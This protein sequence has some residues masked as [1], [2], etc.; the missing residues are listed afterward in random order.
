LID[1]R[2]GKKLELD[3]SYED[4]PFQIGPQSYSNLPNLRANTPADQVETPNIQIWGS[5]NLGNGTDIF[6][7]VFND[8]DQPVF[9]PTYGNQIQANLLETLL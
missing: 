9:I 8:Q 3:K 7:V 5:A 6:N 4:N 1:K 2:T